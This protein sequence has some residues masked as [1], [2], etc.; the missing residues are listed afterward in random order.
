LLGAGIVVGLVAALAS[1]SV[2]QSMLYG[3]H[4]RNPM[5]FGLVCVAIGLVGLT[6]AYIPAVRATKVD[7][8]EALRYE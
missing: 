5:V 7:P 4:S 2:L 6:A 1:S 3:T 8:M